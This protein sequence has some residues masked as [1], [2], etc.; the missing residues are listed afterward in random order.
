LGLAEN[1]SIGIMVP[2]IEEIKEVLKSDL[3]TRSLAIE[4]KQRNFII[5][6]T[7]KVNSYY[8]KQVVQT[9][10]LSLIKDTTQLVNDITVNGPSHSKEGTV[11]HT[12]LT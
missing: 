8:H 11:I 6:L 12:A 1:Q 5:I 10:V 2:I 7:G 9:I 3:R 4:A